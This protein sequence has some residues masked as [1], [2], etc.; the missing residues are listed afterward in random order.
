MDNVEIDNDDELD[1]D[2]ADDDADD[3]NDADEISL[4]SFPLVVSVLLLSFT[5]SFLNLDKKLA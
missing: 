1:A 2:Y 4:S 3:D 5:L